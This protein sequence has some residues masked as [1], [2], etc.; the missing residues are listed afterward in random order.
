[1]ACSDIMDSNT[2]IYHQQEPLLF[3]PPKVTGSIS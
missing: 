3:V 2:K 1:M